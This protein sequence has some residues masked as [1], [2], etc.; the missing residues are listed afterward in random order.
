MRMCERRLDS[1]DPLERIDLSGIGTLG[2]LAD[3]LAVATALGPDLLIDTGGGDSIL[4][5]NIAANDLDADDFL[6]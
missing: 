5:R 1:L 3:V 6:F 2:S 4:L